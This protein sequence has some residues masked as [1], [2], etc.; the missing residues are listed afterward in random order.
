LPH[1]IGA[2]IGSGRRV[3]AMAGDG[4]LALS[5]S[6]L[7]TLA[8]TSADIA[9]IV[10]NDGGY[11]VIRNIQDAEYGSRRMYTDLLNPKFETLCAAFGLPYRKVA[12]A[13]QFVPVLR[14]AIETRGPTVI[15]VDMKAVGGFGATFAGPPVKTEKA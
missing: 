10:M 9:L 6:E 12:A 4:G 2:A 13:D 15:E 8:E 5:F 3:I 11:G 14:A 1:A 7:G